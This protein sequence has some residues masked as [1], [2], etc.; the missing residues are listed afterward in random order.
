MKKTIQT[1]SPDDIIAS[2]KNARW[3]GKSNKMWADLG[4]RT[5]KNIAEGSRVLAILWQ[6]AWKAGNG[7]AIGDSSLV[8]ISKQKLMGLYNTKT[9]CEAFRLRDPKFA[10][11]L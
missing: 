6:S 3:A 7:D 10:A 11:Q 2:W 8:E 9:F 1:L 5:V 4:T